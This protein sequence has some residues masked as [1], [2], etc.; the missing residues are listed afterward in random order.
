MAGFVGM[1][2]KSNENDTITMTQT[3]L[4]DRITTAMGLDDAS[5]KATPTKLGT[6]PKDL[7][8]SLY[9]FDFNCASVVGMLLYLEAHTIL[10]ISFAVNQCSR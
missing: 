5:T 7:K 10:V 8:E 3:G 4:I 9:N 6:F 1:N 2:I